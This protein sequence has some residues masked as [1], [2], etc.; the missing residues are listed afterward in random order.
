M[1][2]SFRWSIKQIFVAVAAAIN[3]GVF[4]FEVKH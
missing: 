4:V 2:S 3:A 1:D